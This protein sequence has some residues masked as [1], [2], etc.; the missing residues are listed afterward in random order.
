MSLVNKES[1]VFRPHRSPHK[2]TSSLNHVHRIITK[3]H[4]YV[5]LGCLPV[6]VY[7][8]YQTF[9]A[10]FGNEVKHQD[11]HNV[12]KEVPAEEIK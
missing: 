6:F 11:I 5:I 12:Q 7:S 10:E 3:I 8:G 9:R 4:K 2:S 1:I